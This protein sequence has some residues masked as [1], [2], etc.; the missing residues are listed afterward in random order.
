VKS[1]YLSIISLKI[2]LLCFRACNFFSYCTKVLFS[3]LYLGHWREYRNTFQF[4][5]QNHRI[6]YIHQRTEARRRNVFTEFLKICFD[7]R[8]FDKAT[9]H[10]SPN[11]KWVEFFKLV[12]TRFNSTFASYVF[13]LVASL[14][15][16]HYNVIL[17]GFSW[18][19][20]I[21]TLNCQLPD[22]V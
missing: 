5:S 15:T 7:T 22:V 18:R 11:T 14:P 20:V 3:R 17:T 9:C 10:V 19:N 21:G 1:W 16:V 8:Q 12:Q 4:K 6:V 13:H 2:W